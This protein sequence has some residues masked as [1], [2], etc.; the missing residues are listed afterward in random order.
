MVPSLLDLSWSCPR[1]VGDLGILLR[2]LP[3]SLQLA[4]RGDSLWV[5]SR[6]D[7]SRQGENMLSIMRKGDL[8]LGGPSLSAHSESTHLLEENTGRAKCRRED[9]SQTCAGTSQLWR[10]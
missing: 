8:D 10:M 2:T 9:A 4:P 3:A 5:D 7:I 6:L 1:A